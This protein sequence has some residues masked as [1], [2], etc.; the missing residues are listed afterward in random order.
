MRFGS[1]EYAQGSWSGQPPVC[2]GW[3]NADFRMM[4]SGRVP[5]ARGYCLCRTEQM[6]FQQNAAVVQRTI[7]AKTS[8]E[9]TKP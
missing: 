2:K 8:E 4:P 1:P 3:A 7:L 9:R 5:T 6:F